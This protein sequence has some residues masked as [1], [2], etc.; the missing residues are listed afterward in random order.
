MESFNNRYIK[1]S[2]LTL[3]LALFFWAIL[4][5]LLRMLGLEDFPVM[6]QVTVSF[7]G[8]GLL[9]YKFLAGKVF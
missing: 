3:F 1:L 4:W 7:L 5:L 9:V 8:A 6:L 2:L